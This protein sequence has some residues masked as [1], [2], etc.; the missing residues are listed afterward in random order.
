MYQHI[1]FFRTFSRVLELPSE[2]WQDYLDN[3]C[4]HGSEA[5]KKLYKDGLNPR[6]HDCFF[7]EWYIL[8]HPQAINTQ[9]VQLGKVIN[10]PK[11]T[12]DMMGHS[13]LSNSLF[14]HFIFPVINQSHVFN[15]IHKKS[16]TGYYCTGRKSAQKVGRPLSWSNKGV[17]S[18]L[19]VPYSRVIF[20]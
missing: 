13:L 1:I 9:N 18:I 19:T 6:E 4:C 5:V 3:W 11:S 8:L 20:A 10:F 7:G 15:A 17:G 2:N 14:F 16:L 12:S